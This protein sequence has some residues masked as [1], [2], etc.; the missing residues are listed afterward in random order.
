MKKASLPLGKMIMLGIFA[1]IFIALGACAGSTAVHSIHD[2]GLARILTG[3]IFPVGLVM[4]VLTGS[5]LFTGNC[6]MITA[7]LDK[8]IHVSQMLRNLAVVYPANL[9]GSLLVALLVFWSGNL[10]YSDG[11]LGAYTI[12]VALGKA[13]LSPLSCIASGILCNILVCL[14]ILLAGTAKTVSGKILGIFF[15]ICTFV[16]CGFEHIVANMY[17]IPAGMIAAIDPEYIKKAE[18]VYHLTSES[19][20]KLS[21]SGLLSNFTFVTVGNIL[22]GMAFV[23]VVNHVI[24]QR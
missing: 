22:G 20:K 21:L 23:G 15:P 1:G 6:L 13:S 11:L 16:T 5:E 4:V 14:A 12:K 2:V 10:N 19:L 18:N 8:K 17:Y 24:H 9:A 3:A 7:V